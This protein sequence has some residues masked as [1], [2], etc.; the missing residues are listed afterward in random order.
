[1]ANSEPSS[2]ALGGTTGAFEWRKWARRAAGNFGIV[3]AGVFLVFLVLTAI[4]A[5]AIAPHDA[6]TGNILDNLKPPGSTSQS[7]LPYV[8]GTDTVGRDVLSGMAYGARISLVVGLLSVFG[9]G[10]IGTVIGIVAG[11]ARGWVDEVVMRLVDI[12]LA[13]PFILLAIVIMYILGRGLMNVIIVLIVATWPMYAR[14]ARAQALK[15]RETEFVQAARSIGAGHWRIMFRHLLPNSLTPLIVVAT[16]AVPQMIIYEAALSFL[17][18]GMPPD[19]VSWGSMLASGRGQLEQ[20]WWVA[21]FPGL[22]IMFTVLSVNLIGD[23]LRDWF[24]PQLRN[25]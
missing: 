22:A 24:D 4:F 2:A 25:L 23:W 3:F 15:L 13:F 1:M 14:V 8:L 20:A 18:V 9:A 11:Y 12:Q 21:T 6:L 10:L 5:P 16:F 17:G 7:G 19:I